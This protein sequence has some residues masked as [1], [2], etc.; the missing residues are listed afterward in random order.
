MA[1]VNDTLVSG[2][3]FPYNLA[4]GDYCHYYE[5]ILCQGSTIFFDELEYFVLFS[6]VILI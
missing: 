1:S 6:K 2:Q 3:D 4:G 5:R